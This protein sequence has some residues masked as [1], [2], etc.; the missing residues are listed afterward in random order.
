MCVWENKKTKTKK[1][2]AFDAPHSYNIHIKWL[3]GFL[4]LV[5]THKVLKTLRP[6]HACLLPVS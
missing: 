5:K 4:S 1:K 6:A 2:T 3:M